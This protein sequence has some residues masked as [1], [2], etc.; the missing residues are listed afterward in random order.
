MGKNGNLQFENRVRRII[1][2]RALKDWAQI[3]YAGEESS[4]DAFLA[5]IVSGCIGLV[6]YWI[7][8]GMKES[9][10]HMAELTESFITRGL[11]VLQH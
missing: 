2:E 6:T 4:L 10:D 8:D 9:P 1:R 5:Y 7:N 11:H 3:R